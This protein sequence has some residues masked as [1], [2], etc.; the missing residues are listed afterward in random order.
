[1]IIDQTQTQAQM[2]CRQESISSFGVNSQNPV[3]IP[4]PKDLS[5]DDVVMGS[6]STQTWKGPSLVEGEEIGAETQMQMGIETRM[7]VEVETE[8]QMLERAEDAVCCCGSK[9]CIT[10]F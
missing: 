4:A 7:E 2:Q 6:Q 8:T 10:C 1:M 5:D 3:Q 9:V